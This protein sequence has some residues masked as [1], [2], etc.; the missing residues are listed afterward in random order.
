M[1]GRGG[2]GLVIRVTPRS[3]G[4]DSPGLSA[5]TPA[6]IYPQLHPESLICRLQHLLLFHLLHHFLEIMSNANWKPFVFGGLASV[7]AECGA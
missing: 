3:A 2:R 6:G 1:G 4:V 7:T 5:H